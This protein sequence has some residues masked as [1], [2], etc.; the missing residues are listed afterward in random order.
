MKLQDVDSLH[1]HFTNASTIYVNAL[2][3]FNDDKSQQECQIGI[4]AYDD[5]TDDD[6]FFW[7]D[8]VEDFK[9]LFTEGVNDFK[10]IEFSLY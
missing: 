10:V 1:K 5:E 2:V 3:E 4:G 6:V 9:S 7:C 8:S